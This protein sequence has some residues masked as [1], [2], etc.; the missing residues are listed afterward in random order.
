MYLRIEEPVLNTER[1]QSKSSVSTRARVT[2]CIMKIYQMPFKKVWKF[3][4]NAINKYFQPS[5][6][7]TPVVSLS[8]CHDLMC[9]KKDEALYWMKHFSYRLAVINVCPVLVPS[10]LLLSTHLPTSE[11]WTAEL[12]VGLWL[13]VPTTGFEPTRGD[14]T[15]FETLRL[16]HSAT[17]AANSLS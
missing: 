10:E 13:V 6:K 9:Y 5:L 14:L 16:N 15:R 11:G 8:T 1:H 12:T 3:L 7:L 2:Y 4:A 17:L